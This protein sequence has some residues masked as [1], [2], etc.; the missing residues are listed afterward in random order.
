M[1]F[2]FVWALKE[3]M[4]TTDVLIFNGRE[5]PYEYFS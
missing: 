1:K 3:K 5:N 2:F 4:F